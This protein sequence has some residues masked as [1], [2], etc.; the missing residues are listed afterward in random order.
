LGNECELWADLEFFTTVRTAPEGPFFHL[1]GKFSF[2][3]PDNRSIDFY[4]TEELYLEVGNLSSRFSGLKLWLGRREYERR[5]IHINDYFFLDLR[6]DGLGFKDWDI[7]VGKLAYTYSRDEFSLSGEPTQHGHDFRLYD[8]PVNQ[9]GKL[10]LYAGY[11]HIDG[12]N[13]LE[14]ADGYALSLIHRQ[15]GVFGGFNMFALQYGKGTGFNAGDGMSIGQE[16]ASLLTS[17]TAASN[18]EKAR[19][20]RLVNQTLL[21]SDQWAMM[22]S[23]VFEDKDFA[24]FDGTDQ[25]WL[26]LGLR[27]MWFVHK[28]VRLVGE[29]GHDR[30]ND[31]LTDTDGGLTK[32]TMAVEFARKQGFWERPVLRLF[33]TYAWWSDEWQGQVG[34]T[35][36][37]DDTEGWSVGLQVEHWW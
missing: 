13:T 6:G 15:E 8:L 28:N 27:P 21:E 36:Y 10:L 19:T 24:E 26:S 31:E 9:G 30:V 2:L 25:R 5:D 20:W 35:T 37:A 32:L 22:A 29:L 11:S 18:L 1:E 34:G 7:G 12:G 4:D 16:A 33:G 3:G 14:D 23:I 17:A